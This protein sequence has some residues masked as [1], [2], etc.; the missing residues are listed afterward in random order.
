MHVA[1]DIDKLSLKTPALDQNRNERLSSIYNRASSA[2][3]VLIDLKEVSQR[4][5]P[6][7]S[8]QLG[9]E[10]PTDDY[11]DM[12]IENVTNS[13]QISGHSKP[14]ENVTELTR[15]S[16]PPTGKPMILK[17]DPHTRRHEHYFRNNK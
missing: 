12:T 10:S 8:R 15:E 16:I 11:K 1:L 7:L 17:L 13:R 6:P 5:P 2:L 4:L 3:Q 14:Q 9:A